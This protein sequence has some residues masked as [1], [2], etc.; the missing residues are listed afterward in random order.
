MDDAEY[1]RKL[2]WVATCM[3]GSDRYCQYPIAC[4]TLWIRPAILLDRIHFFFDRSGGVS[5][6]FTW[7]HLAQDT[8]KRLL[9]EPSPLL[10][11]SE[12]NEGDRLWVLDFVNLRGGVQQKVS[13]IAALFPDEQ[14]ASALR[15]HEDGSVRKV[16]LWRR[17]A[18]GQRAIRASPPSERCHA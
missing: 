9:D 16:T 4:L 7:A 2:G 17:C 10:H 1:H 5:G 15:R 14:Q 13:Q 12:W 18:S 11:V 3:M 6:Y 8:Q